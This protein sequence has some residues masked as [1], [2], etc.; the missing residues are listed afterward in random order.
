MD[1]P[2]EARLNLVIYYLRSG[3][4]GDA[5]NLIKELEPTTPQEYILKAVVH[6]SIG[7]VS[8]SHVMSR[9]MSPGPV[10][11]ASFRPATPPDERRR[12]ALEDGAAVLPAGGRLRI[13]VRHHPRPPGERLLQPSIKT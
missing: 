10:A 5:F 13:R 7:Q 8:V 11:S 12:G 6:A 2:L 4:T 9:V 1:V 3:E